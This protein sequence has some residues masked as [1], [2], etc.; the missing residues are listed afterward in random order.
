MEVADGGD[1]GVGFVSPPATWAWAWG[2]DQDRSVVVVVMLLD[3]L[4]LF[5]DI[6]V[7][8]ALDGSCNVVGGVSGRRR[9][10]V[11]TRTCG[12]QS[13]EASD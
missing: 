7:F 9:R 10:T 6:S 2:V 12:G 13:M 8:P 1:M 5:F 4:L 11:N 3:M